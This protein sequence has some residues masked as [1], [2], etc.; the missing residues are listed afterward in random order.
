MEWC[1][2]GSSV[3]LQYIYIEVR[4]M[5]VCCQVLFCVTMQA[6]KVKNELVSK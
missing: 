3:C 1:A 4:F 6:G 2:G 5:F